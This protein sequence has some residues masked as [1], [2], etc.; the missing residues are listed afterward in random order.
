MH[1]HGVGIVLGVALL[2]VPASVTATVPGDLCV[3]NPCVI[4]ADADIDD[5]SHLDFGAT[6]DV[7]IEEDVTLT[8][9]GAEPDVEF[10]AKSIVLEAGAEIR[11]AAGRTQGLDLVLYTY[12][13]NLE[14]R[15]DGTKR[16]RLDLS[17]PDQAS[18]Y[19]TATGGSILFDGIVD[20]RAGLAAAPTY[21]ADVDIRLADSLFNGTVRGGFTQINAGGDVE[22]VGHVT[23]A[24]PEEGGDLSI[25]ADGGVT[26]RPEGTLESSSSAPGAPGGSIFVSAYGGDIEHEGQV[27]GTSASAALTTQASTIQMYSAVGSVVLTGTIDVSAGNNGE[28]A[29]NSEIVAPLGDINQQAGA[30]IDVSSKGPGG[31]SY[32]ISFLAG[33]NI[34]LGD[35]VIANGGG[36]GGGAIEVA[37]GLQVVVEGELSAK[38]SNGGDA[39]EIELSACDVDVS[40][41]LSVDVGSTGTTILEGGRQVVVTGQ[42]K[43]GSSNE[44]RYDLNEPVLT[45]T[46]SPAPTVSQTADS[47]GCAA[48]ASCGNGL[49]D[50]G[51]GCDDGNLVDGDCCDSS[52]LAESAGNACAV[53]WGPCALS[54]CDGLGACGIATPGAGCWMSVSPLRSQLTITDKDADKGDLVLF[55]WIKGEEVSFGALPDPVGSDDVDFCLYAPDGRP[56]FHASAPAGGTC[57]GKPCWIAKSTGYKY[58]DKERT[59]DGV[60][61]VLLKAG[62]AGKA[63][64]QL[65]GKGENLPDLPELP[66]GVPT[67]AELKGANGACWEAT[68]DGGGVLRNDGG[69]FKAKA[70]N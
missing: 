5:G 40:G 25:E 55:K 6:T 23:T 37:A 70:T 41:K 8:V 44:V 46:I 60:L 39:G 27:V 14:L 16:A 59:P 19:F 34:S 51:E 20:G 38:A 11:G 48:L 42:I 58:A 54:Q 45:G 43:A 57:G 67:R 28:S 49:L 15:V 36:Q 26:I 4:S 12:A 64:A 56:V 63:K 62:D 35:D 1:S 65:K 2:T 18:A 30:T 13:G 50:V 3:G 47:S 21:D 52:C 17:G 66:L 69:G 53:D 10:D 9:L 22:I 7:V 24:G 33:G 68:F 61:K 31:R 32:G 29:D